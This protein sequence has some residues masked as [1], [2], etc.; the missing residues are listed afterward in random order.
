[1]TSLDQVRDGWD[2]AAQRDAMGFILTTGSPWSQEA[3]FAH[4]RQEIAGC[5]A[6]LDVAGIKRDRTKRALDFGCGVGRLSQA[7]AEHYDR[8]DGVDL[9]PSMI[10]QA[11]AF[12]QYGDRVQ[13]RLTG[14]RLPFGKATFDFVYSMLVLQHMPQV[15]QHEYIRDFIRV[16]RPGGLAVFEIPDGP[17][18]PHPESCLSMYGVAYETVQQ[19][20]QDAG[21]KVVDAEV[22]QS[23]VWEC[24]RYAAVVA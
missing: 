24:Y 6:H 16:L 19:I 13:Y 4:G 14:E 11:A 23:G 7:L 18:V 15:F 12:N 20:V 5:F 2:S 22:I 17:D 10:K 1:M 3:F 9:A 21:G 8:V